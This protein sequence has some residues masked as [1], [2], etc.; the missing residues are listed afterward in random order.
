MWHVKNSDYESTAHSLLNKAGSSSLAEMKLGNGTLQDFTSPSS[1]PTLSEDS[2]H[3]RDVD[4]V[5]IMELSGDYQ[6]I[7]L[8]D[9]ENQMEMPSSPQVDQER[10]EL[11]SLNQNEAI[12]WSSYKCPKCPE[13]FTCNVQRNKHVIVCPYFDTDSGTDEDSIDRESCI[14]KL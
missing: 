2:L 7:M 1:P 10:S 12:W 8:I 5:H 6:D 4:P 14:E 9:D 13:A 3:V 11:I